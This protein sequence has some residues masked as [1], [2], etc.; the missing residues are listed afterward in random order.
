MVVAVILLV[1]LGE[2]RSLYEIMPILG[3]LIAW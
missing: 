2:I 3:Y 1:T